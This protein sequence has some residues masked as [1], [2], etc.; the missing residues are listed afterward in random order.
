MFFFSG[1]N[2]END[3]NECE[4]NPCLNNGTCLQLSDQSLYDAAKNG[5]TTLPEVFNQ[6]FNYS[7]A[8]G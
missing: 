1:K 4:S 8:S 2:C 5:D 6:D 7:I 3:R